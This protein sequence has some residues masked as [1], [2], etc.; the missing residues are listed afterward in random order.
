M[1]NEIFEADDPSSLSSHELKNRNRQHFIFGFLA[2]IIRIYMT[3]YLKRFFE[4]FP[5][6]KEAAWKTRFENVTEAFLNFDFKSQKSKETIRRALNVSFIIYNKGQAFR[7][8]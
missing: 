3:N 6:I 5:C 7:Y 2:K 8:E 4:E 1:G